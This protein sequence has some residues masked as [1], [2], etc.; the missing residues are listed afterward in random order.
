M[1]ISL[2]P[3]ATVVTVLSPA[4]AGEQGERAVP[5]PEGLGV[6]FTYQPKLKEVSE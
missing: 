1:S 3:Q 4:G 6:Q 2:C 5:E